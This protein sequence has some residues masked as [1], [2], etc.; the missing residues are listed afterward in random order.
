MGGG[1]PYCAG[2]KAWP[3]FNDLITWAQ[4]N[5]RLYLID[6]WDYV[7]NGKIRPET[8]TRGSHQKVWWTCPKGH[9]YQADIHNRTSKHSSGCPF[10][11]SERISINLKASLLNKN[12]SLAQKCP[13]IA[14]EWDYKKNGSLTPNDI[15]CSGKEKY[16]WVCKKGHSYKMELNHRTLWEVHAS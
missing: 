11:T 6:E 9:S 7:K 14:S 16:W 5:G 10:C 4:E 8:L 15:T 3:G 13:D 1:C 12:G 2:K